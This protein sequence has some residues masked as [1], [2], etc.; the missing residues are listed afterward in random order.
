[1]RHPI[2]VPLLSDPTSLMQIDA[3]PAGDGQFR[4]VGA[5]AAR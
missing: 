3:T 2:F 4:L 1:M 5:R